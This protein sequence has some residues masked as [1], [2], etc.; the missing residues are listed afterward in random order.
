M[1]CSVPKLNGKFGRIVPHYKNKKIDHVCLE[2][3]YQNILL[4]CQATVTFKKG[5]LYFRIKINKNTKYIAVHRLVYAFIHGYIPK[6]HHVHHNDEDKLNN[7]PKN[8]KLLLIPVHMKLHGRNKSEK[9]FTE[10]KKK[11]EKVCD[12]CK[13]SQPIRFFKAFNDTCKQCTKKGLIADE[14]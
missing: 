1:K 9:T 13:K 4:T 14:L 3:K 5:Y 6:T 2:G 7:F 11:Q 12:V 10:I 8:L